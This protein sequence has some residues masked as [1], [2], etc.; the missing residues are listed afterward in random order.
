M[1]TN[2]MAVTY[3]WNLF[4]IKHYWL[5]ILVKFGTSIANMNTW[6]SYNFD[7]LEIKANLNNILTWISQLEVWLVCQ[8]VC[9]AQKHAHIHAK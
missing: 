1:V 8:Y 7:T 4:S 9:D 6:R 5:H 2:I 3:I